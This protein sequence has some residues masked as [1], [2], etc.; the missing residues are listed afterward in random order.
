MCASI[1]SQSCLAGIAVGFLLQLKSPI[2]YI[3]LGF[4]TI[5][6]MISNSAAIAQMP[7]KIVFGSFVTAVIV[8][9]IVLISSL[10]LLYL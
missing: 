9:T 3:F 1:T 2:S 5:V 4:V 6:S 10:T 8:T 7:I